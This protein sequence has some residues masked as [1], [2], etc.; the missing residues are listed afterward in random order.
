MSVRRAIEVDEAGEGAIEIAFVIT[1]RSRQATRRALGVAIAALVVL[2]TAGEVARLGFGRDTLFG[3]VRLFGLGQEANVPTWY[4]SATL[5]VAAAL[6]G[7]AAL[8]KHRA[9]DPLARRWTALAALLALMSLDETAAI[10]ESIPALAAYRLLGEGDSP[11]VYYAWIVPGA[12]IAAAIVWWFTSLWRGLRRDV[13]PRFANAAAIY[14]G[15]AVG[16]EVA[17]AACAAV[18][19][20]ERAATSP[21]YSALWTTQEALEMIGVAALILALLDHLALERVALTRRV[22]GS[23]RGLRAIA[24]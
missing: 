24:D 20:L 19:G 16:V 18:L 11:F 2:G 13:R 9:R 15:G 17:E 5:L 12:A 6:A 4:S 7:T 10:H 23:A 22:E 8:L 1:Q 3:F 21:F 14:F